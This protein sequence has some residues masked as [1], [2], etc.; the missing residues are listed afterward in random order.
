M[1]TSLHVCLP[2]RPL[3][4]ALNPS[5]A[6]AGARPCS[7][8]SS[9]TGSPDTLLEITPLLWLSVKDLLNTNALIVDTQFTII[10]NDNIHTLCIIIDKS[11]GQ[12]GIKMS[13]GYRVTSNKSGSMPPLIHIQS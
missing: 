1:A 11:A 9:P 6:A 10:Q 3:M 4:L 7:T 12:T 8:F 2:S 5:T 13:V